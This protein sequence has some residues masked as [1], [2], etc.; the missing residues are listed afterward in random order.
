MPTRAI[1]LLALLAAVALLAVLSLLGS[2]VAGIPALGRLLDPADGL[3]RQARH[4]KAGNDVRVVP[5]LAAEVE[6]YFDSRG[7]P[8][9]YGS[10]DLDVVRTF[11]YVVARDR[12]FQ[13]DFISRLAAGRLSSLLG[14]DAIESDRYLRRTGMELGTVLNAERI[15]RDQG[16][17]LALIEAFCD[18]VNHYVLSL[19]PADYPLE[20][21]LLD[22]TPE[23]CTLEM[24][25]RI[26]QYMTYDLSFQSDDIAYGTMKERLSAEEYEDL[27]GGVS[28][29]YVPIIPDSL[30]EGRVAGHSGT[31]VG[32]ELRNRWIELHRSFAG[33]P[34]EGFLHGKGSNNWAVDGSRSTTGFPILAGDMHLS[35]SL[36]AIW[37]EARLSGST[38]NLYGVAVPGSPLPIQS[39]NKD[40]GWAFTNTGSDQIDH[41]RITL[42]STRTRYQHNGAWRDLE[43][44]IDTIQV[45]GARPVLDTML[46][47]HW[48]PVLLGEDDI[49]I[50]WV[51]HREN[52]VLAAVAQM[53]RAS[54]LSEFEEA[55]RSWDAPMQNILYADRHGTIAIRS[56]GS[57]PV[58]QDGTGAGVLDGSSDGGAWNGV[59][60]FE[61]LPYA[62]N[63]PSGFLTSTNQN[64]VG[65]GYTH[66]LGHDWRPG[67]RSLRIDRLLRSK[68]RH[69][70]EDLKAYQADVY[71]MQRELFFPFIDTLSELTSEATLVRGVIERWDGYAHPDLAGPLAFKYFFDDLKRLTWD[72]EVFVGGRT[73]S[74]STLWR[75]LSEGG[76]SS[77]FNR[78]DTDETENGADILRQALES[79]GRRLRADFDDDTDAWRWGYANKVIFRHLM[80]AEALRALWRGPFTFGGF[81]ETL[82]PASGTPVV[83]SASWRVVLDFSA[84]P[85]IA[86]GI[87]PG[88]QSGNPLDPSYDGHIDD[89]LAHRYYRLEMPRDPADHSEY[90]TMTRQTF[91]P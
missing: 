56:T 50:Q 24:P 77:W 29:L 18:G 68:E 90:E 54:N 62:T 65:R 53:S 75:L 17:E 91:T 34:L 48:G 20:Y 10:D 25:L 44:R 32:A 27:F 81:A 69:S 70:P 79:A 2:S 3:Y 22:A 37:Y 66:Y 21:R 57:L 12:L 64:P 84:S 35:L 49:A 43:Q 61:E 83:H 8:H 71:A 60:P 73:P 58:R 41:Y 15:R 52:R 28:P 67:Y 63:P 51:A 87:Y 85:P 40:L 33:T 13:M 59:M 88:G 78:E 19:A 47:S 1:S 39:F 74:E 89:Y 55:L 16:E 72:E 31:A 45:K 36:P 38:L 26:A 30:D 11:G 5:G 76:S 86:Y 7:V 23:Q 42:D 80:R 82:L 4:A 9:I 46:V 14:P 6:V